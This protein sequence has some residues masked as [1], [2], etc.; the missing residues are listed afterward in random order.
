MNGM[1]HIEQLQGY[2]ADE[3]I[4]GGTAMIAKVVFNAMYQDFSKGRPTEIDY[5]NGYIA[6]LGREHDYICRTHEFVVHEVHLAEQMAALKATQ[7]VMD[8]ALA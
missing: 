6:K 7:A 4:I 3:E 1:G 5:I 8:R 2:F